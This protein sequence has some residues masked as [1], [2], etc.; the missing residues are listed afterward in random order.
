MADNEDDD[1]ALN[2]VKSMPEVAETNTR[3]AAPI[4]RDAEIT[5][6]PSQVQSVRGKHGK[7]K[8]MKEKYADQDDEEKELVLSLLGSAGAR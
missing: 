6:V 1:T 8:K 4:T 7:I 3:A 5:N 2:T